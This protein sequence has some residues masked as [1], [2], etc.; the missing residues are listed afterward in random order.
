MHTY[1]NR[2]CT[3]AQA[4]YWFFISKTSSKHLNHTNHSNESVYVEAQVLAASLS[5]NQEFAKCSFT[6]TTTKTIHT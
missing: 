3:L 5:V 6:E 2:I 4:I 1:Y